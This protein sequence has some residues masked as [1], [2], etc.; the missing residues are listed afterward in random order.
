MKILYFC[1][2]KLFILGFFCVGK[3]ILSS[4]WCR[5]INGE[6]PILIWIKLTE[7]PQHIDSLQRR[8]LSFCSEN[9][10]GYSIFLMFCIICSASSFCLGNVFLTCLKTVGSFWTLNQFPVFSVTDLFILPFLGFLAVVKKIDPNFNGKDNLLF[11]C[12][13]VRIMTCS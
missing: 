5:F 9:Y 12:K 8:I 4:E 7:Y 13:S 10:L 11:V 6:I 2:M 3:V 1:Q